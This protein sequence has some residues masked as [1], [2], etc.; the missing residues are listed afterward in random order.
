MVKVNILQLLT[1]YVLQFV[2][3]ELYICCVVLIIGNVEVGPDMDTE[4]H[5]LRITVILTLHSMEIDKRS[6][7]EHHVVEAATLAITTV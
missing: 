6:N 5:Y 2:I 7:L 4:F 1:V 3:N